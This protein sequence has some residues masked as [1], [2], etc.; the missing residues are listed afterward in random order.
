MGAGSF[1][2]QT[3]WPGCKSRPLC[4]GQ[5]VAGFWSSV[6]GDLKPLYSGFFR[7]DVVLGRCGPMTFAETQLP[8][9]QGWTE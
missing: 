7:K 8:V 5:I 1:Y 4:Q 6:L 2:P 9:S 3:A